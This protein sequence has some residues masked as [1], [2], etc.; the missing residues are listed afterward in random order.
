MISKA[1]EMVIENWCR[2]IDGYGFGF[3]DLASVIESPNR[4][5]IRHL[6]LAYHYLNDRPFIAMAGDLVIPHL[7]QKEYAHAIS[8]FKEAAYNRIPRALLKK[9]PNGDYL[10]NYEYRNSDKVSGMVNSLRDIINNK[11]HGKRENPIIGTETVD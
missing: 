10:L 1:Q 6:V 8:R 4:C 9:L 2:Y 7:K 11:Q 3:I 5:D